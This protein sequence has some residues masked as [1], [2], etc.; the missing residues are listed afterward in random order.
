[1]KDINLLNTI[2]KII[3]VLN[4]MPEVGNGNREKMIKI[5]IINPEIK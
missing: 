1:M 3:G 4:C 5:Y 2:S